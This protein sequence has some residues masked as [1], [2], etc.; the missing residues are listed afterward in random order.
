M[1]QD[2]FRSPPRSLLGVIADLEAQAAKDGIEARSVG[3]LICQRRRVLVLIRADAHPFMS[4]MGDLPGGYALPEESLLDALRRETK[5]ETGFD[6]VE[7]RRYLSSFDFVSGRGLRVRQFNFE[8]DVRGGG[9]LL[10]PDEHKAYRWC[11]PG[12]MEELKRLR[13]TPEARSVI[14]QA[15]K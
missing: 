2:Q 14:R 4:G 7:I 11:E 9:V 12:N 3:A 13:V 5:E 1:T 8:V 10:T 15:C 6:V